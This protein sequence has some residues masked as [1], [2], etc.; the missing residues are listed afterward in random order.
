MSKATEKED[1]CEAVDVADLSVRSFTK[2]TEAGESDDELK[3]NFRVHA[4]R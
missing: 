4:S 2:R 3:C 1:C